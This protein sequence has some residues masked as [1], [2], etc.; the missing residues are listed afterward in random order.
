[1]GD[2]AVSATCDYQA[3]TR[4]AAGATSPLSLPK[5]NVLAWELEGG[6]RVTLRPSGTEPK[7]KVYLE[8]REVLTTGEPMAP[9]HQR[10]MTRL[11]G[12]Q[13]AFLAEA[14]TRGL[15]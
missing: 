8:L 10:A 11:A 13:T 3:Q 14:K 12:L 5:S 2:F 15:P 7:I 4:T 9:A 1:V 6:S